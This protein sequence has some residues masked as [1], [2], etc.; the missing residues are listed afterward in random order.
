MGPNHRHAE[1][2]NANA[3]TDAEVTLRFARPDDTDALAVLA[4]LDYSHTL[5]GP[6]LVA[7]VSGELWA[8]VSR[9]N[10]H[11]VADPFRPSGELTR[12]FLERARQLRRTEHGLDRG[13]RGAWPAAAPDGIDVTRTGAR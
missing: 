11:A 6:V 8:A 7:A 1:P 13:V 9:E 5:P 3:L 10:G 12:L 4:A 2:T